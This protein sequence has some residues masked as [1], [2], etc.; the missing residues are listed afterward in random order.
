MP[1]E[2]ISKLLG[3]ENID[4]TMIYAHTS[5]EAVRAGHQ[6]HIV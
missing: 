6:K 1:V 3:H 5:L 2:E 4:T